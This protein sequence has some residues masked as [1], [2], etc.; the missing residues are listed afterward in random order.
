[1]GTLPNSKFVTDGFSTIVWVAVA[2][3]ESV[4]GVACVA[5]LL[6]KETL[7]E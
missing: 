5:A 2:V 1:M 7:P 4:T 6:G 3:P